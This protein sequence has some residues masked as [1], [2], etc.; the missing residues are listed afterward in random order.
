MS[1]KRKRRR[2][3]AEARKNRPPTKLERISRAAATG[4][5]D[6]FMAEVERR[7][8]RDT[9]A[10]KVGRAMGAAMYKHVIKGGQN[11]GQR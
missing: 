2:A 8:P 7:A 10:S 6:A 1:S 11:R 3:E 4:D 5:I 9:P